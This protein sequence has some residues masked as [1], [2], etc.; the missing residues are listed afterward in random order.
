MDMFGKFVH[1]YFFIL[2]Y[3]L[4]WCLYGAQNEAYKTIY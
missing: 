2:H 1:E 3:V 4:H